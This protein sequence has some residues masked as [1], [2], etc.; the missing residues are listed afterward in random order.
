M[1][2]IHSGGESSPALGGHSGRWDIYG[3]TKRAMP[4]S[5]ISLLQRIFHWLKVDSIHMG[6]DF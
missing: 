1:Y 3:I 4:S 5:P 6:L 2:F